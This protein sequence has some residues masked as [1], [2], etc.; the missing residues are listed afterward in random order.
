MWIINIRHWLN[1]EET[2]P[3]VPQLRLKV[4]KLSEIITYA[5]L[6]ECGLDAGKAPKCWRRPGR[7]PCKD[8]LQ[9]QF[10]PDGRIHWFCPKCEDEG[11]L[12]GWQ[13][14]IWDMSDGITV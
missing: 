10:E 7:K 4:K 1:E 5:T 9:V 2:G 13:G 14:L 12:D 6:R 11:V 3:A 8:V